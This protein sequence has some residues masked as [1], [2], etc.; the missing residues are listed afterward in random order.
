LN[1]SVKNFSL[2]LSYCSDIFDYPN[3]DPT[4]KFSYIL[5]HIPIDINRKNL[6]DKKS[7]EEFQSDYI[8]LFV[9][10]IKGVQCVP[11]ASWWSEKRLMG[12]ETQKVRKFYNKCGFDINENEIKTPPD[13]ISLEIGFL[14]RLIEENRW[15]ES[16]E[17]ID[18]H[19][20]WIDEFKD[21]IKKKDA[22]YGLAIEAVC[23][24][25]DI[26]KQEDLC[27]KTQ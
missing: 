13:H 25:I 24:I 7:L 6:I 9:N 15:K 14:S 11:Y 23:S 20:N 18:K 8:N 16:C 5:K 1:K 10:N 17:M 4:K 2:L 22:F 12:K 26:I 27:L 19:L 21:C 3:S